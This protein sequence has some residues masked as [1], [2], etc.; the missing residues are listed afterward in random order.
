MADQFVGEVRIF[1]GNFP[2]TGWAY[3]DGALLPISQNTALFS[4]LGTNYGGDGKST[5]GLPNLQGAFPMHAGSGAGP[6]LT[7]RLTGETGGA[8][9]VAL[10]KDQIPSHNHA[11]NTAAGAT[12]GTPDGT[13]SLAPNS[14]GHAMYHHATP[15]THGHMDA[16]TVLAAGGGAPHDNLQPYL[17][18][19]FII[20]LQGIFPP[21][22]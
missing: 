17:A 1:A 22:P 14:A 8:E 7:Q 11:V 9:S 10:T 13:T 19:S 20:A 12:A 5:F 15:K 3:C 2:P 18:L 21:R 16:S 6:G 4:L